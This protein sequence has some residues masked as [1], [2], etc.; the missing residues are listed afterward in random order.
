MDA[1]LGGDDEAERTKDGG[2]AAFRGIG[3]RI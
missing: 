3:V 1:E 2:D